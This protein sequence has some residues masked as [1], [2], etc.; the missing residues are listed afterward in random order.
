MV[1]SLILMSLASILDKYQ[2]LGLLVVINVAAVTL[3]SILSIYS[4]IFMLLPHETV[5]FILYVTNGVFASVAL[6]FSNVLP[7]MILTL[8]RIKEIYHKNV[9][10]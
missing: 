3:F 10:L 2:K 9:G 7:L 4:N 6:P 5:F 1:V 8:T